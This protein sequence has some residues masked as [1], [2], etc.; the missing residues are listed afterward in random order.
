MENLTKVVTLRLTDPE[1]EILRKKAL[2]CKRTVSY[3]ARETYRK[4]ATEN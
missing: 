4:G 1:Y 2:D 3:V